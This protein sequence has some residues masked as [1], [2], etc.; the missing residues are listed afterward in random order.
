M[1]L[2]LLEGQRSQLGHNRLDAHHLSKATRAV[3]S[4]ALPAG[5]PGALANTSLAIQALL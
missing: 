5:C 1:V 3:Q 4:E 2:A